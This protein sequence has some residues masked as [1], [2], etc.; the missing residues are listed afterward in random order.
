MRFSQLS[1]VSA[2][3][4]MI[5][6]LPLSVFS[7]VDSS[8][9]PEAA[10]VPKVIPEIARLT[11]LNY[12]GLDSVEM[13]A[14]FE[15]GVFLPEDMENRVQQFINKDGTTP[16]NPF[17]PQ[18]LSIEATFQYQGAEGV[19]EELIFGYYHEE[20]ER[21]SD[22]GRWS[23]YTPKNW[24]FFR[25]R[26]APKKAGNWTCMV[27]V[28]VPGE[29]RVVNSTMLA[30]NVVDKGH[31][32]FVR[33]SDNKQYLELDGKLFLP[34]GM[35]MPTIGGLMT[36]YR[37]EG[38]LPQE[39]EDYHKAL[40]ELKKSGGNYFRYMHTPW[41]TE[42]EFEHL[43]DYSNRLAQ[44]WEMDRIVDEIE[45]LDLRMHFD[46]SYTTPLTYT[47]VFSLYRWDWTNAKDTFLTCEGAPN[48]VPD[49]AGYCYHTD[50][51]LG[52]DKIDEF[53]SDPELIRYY[54]N[55]IRYIVA[56]W[57]YSTN[58]VALELMNEINFSGVRYGIK[59]DCGFDP[60]IFEHKPYFHDTSY[61]G[62]L[63]RWQVEMGRYIKEDLK[64]LDHP[65]C[66]NYGGAPNYVSASEYQFDY[67]DGISLEAGDSTY[68]SKYVDI[69]T[70]NDY[71]GWLEKY[72][73]A[74]QDLKRLKKYYETEYTNGKSFEKPLFYSEIGMGRHG[75]DNRFT[76]KQLFIMS[77]FSGA[78]GGGLP[79]HFNNNSAEFHLTEQREDAWSTMNV[80]KEFFK[81]V[82]L[83]KGEWFTGV[84]VRKDKKAEVLFLR[85]G[86]SSAESAV[87]VI[88]NRTVNRY[89]MREDWCDDEPERCD[90]YLSEETLTQ[91]FPDVYQ[92][93]VPVKWNDGRVFGGNQLL[94]ISG[95]EYTSKY[96][97]VYYDGLSGETVLEQTKWSDALGN[98]KLRYPELSD[99][100]EKGK[101]A[102]GSML[103]VKVWKYDSPSFSE[104]ST[105]K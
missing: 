93:A 33:I 72:Q 75:C 79:W 86:E 18:E 80:I 27:K 95:M 50:P 97:I 90:C 77:P 88:N 73:Y 87:A 49:D 19:E 78:M 60:Y 5:L 66:V 69:V 35:N 76:Y 41:T 8:Q 3:C 59:P 9:I 99:A 71:F 65:F 11:V 102:N 7:Q 12:D 105:E 68:F 42:I 45:K 24:P 82:P 29:H 37:R 1:C 43:G 34:V 32:G 16:L 17:D 30:F 39:Y 83:N 58:I 31:S 22:L 46:L 14:K 26:F 52:V 55:R 92:K 44:A 48:W 56:R 74:S 104:K 98:L 91:F 70:Y 53:L 13:N 2:V 103:L 85:D 23:R 36:G 4:L 6:F 47:G 61:V 28:V 89:T 40:E 54:Q 62:K 94:K 21:R 15:I 101:N 84:D 10:P 96:R 57:G 38:A 51:E 63:C 67:E 20:Y 81:D 64:S 100:P 25:V